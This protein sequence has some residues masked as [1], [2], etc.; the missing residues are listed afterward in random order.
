MKFTNAPIAL[1]CVCIAVVSHSQIKITGSVTNSSSQPLHGA[2]ILLLKAT[3]SSLVKGLASAK[4]GSFSFD[5]VKKGAYVVMATSTGYTASY[6]PLLQVDETNANINL[7]PIELRDDVKQ[8]EGVNVQSRRP[9]LEQKIDR[10]VV[11]VKNSITSAGSTA[12]D[13]LERS[14][15]VI[16]NRQAN[17]ITMRGKD[18]VTVMINGK[19]NYM[20]LSALVEMLDGMNAANIDRI[21]LI[22]SPPA[23]LDAQG[24]AGYINIVLLSNPDFG[25]NGSFTAGVGYGDGA[26]TNNNVNF[27]FRR[28]KFNLYG[29]YS[30]GISARKPYFHNYRRVEDQ[31][32]VKESY[33][34]TDRFPTRYTHN[35]RIGIDYQLSKRTILGFI[36][37]GF[38]NRY[39]M[40]ETINN[41]NYLNAQKDTL[42]VISNK[43]VNN[44]KHA[45]F[46]LNLQHT[47]R[48]GETMSVDADYLVYKNNQPFNY[49]NNYYNGG[50]QFLF[51]ENVRTGKHTPIKFYVF[52]L[53]YSKALNDKITIETGIKA[54]KSRFDND[55]VIERSK[56]G[57]WQIDPLYTS[58]AT[59]KEDI[60]AA[61]LS[62]NISP[63]EQV[64]LKLGL[65]YEYTNSNLGTVTQKDLVDRHYGRLFPALFISRKLSDN[66][67]LNLSYNRRINRP[68]FTDMAPFIFFFDP[69][70]Y[71]SGNAALQPSISDNFTVD[72]SFSKKLLSLGYTYENDFIALFQSK[73][74]PKT[75]KQVLFTDNLD[76]VKSVSLIFALPVDITKWWSLQNNITGIW[77]QVG[78][79]NENGLSK[80]NIANVNIS[81]IQ[82]FQL[83]RNYAAEISGSYQSASLSGIYKV[84]PYGQLDAGIQK[85]FKH[86]NEKLRLSVSDIFSTN[87]YQWTTNTGN[88][89][90]SRTILQFTKVTISLSYSR[91]FGRT[92]VKAARERALGSAEESR[93]VRN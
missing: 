43:E 67:T 6:L 14:P 59:L 46:N 58:S 48:A 8:L 31:G 12:L 7:K 76:F 52:K 24:N 54:T 20:P 90:F 81:V 83:S 75:N 4:D 64:K 18:G 70:T 41:Q 37:S 36:A 28:N 78:I 23:N 22:T 35:A 57:A 60:S 53:D 56:G 66:Q 5:Q 42:I 88:E 62:F 25:F 38:I 87:K 45:K 29:D 69:N 85:K 30:M 21:E 1:A 86:N 13:V 77:Q 63:N 89:N 73:I 32:E 27:N 34:V 19:I 61:H 65:R 55:V 26:T 71:F 40:H 49:Q 72:Y 15:G 17:S 84:K 33:T 9:L 82:N 3:D 80:F 39:D 92:S 10:L 50:D 91:S 79:S 2:N 74:D 44:W 16:V 93:R 11:N 68:A 51:A 47:F